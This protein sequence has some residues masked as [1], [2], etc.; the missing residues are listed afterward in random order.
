MADLTAIARALD[1]VED[2]LQEPIGV[3]DMADAADYS[4][5]HFCRTFGQAAHV[6]PYDYLMRRRLAEAAKDLLQS[7]DKIIDVAFDYQFNNPETFSRA[8]RRTFGLPPSQWRQEGRLDCRHIMP[9]LTLD[10]LRHLAQGPYLKPRLVD[11]EAL[12][13]AGLMTPDGA[14]PQA[15]RRIWSLLAADVA[16]NAV[17]DA[18]A[19]GEAAGR[20]YYGLLCYRNERQAPPCYLA[21]FE[22]ES[23]DGGTEHPALVTKQIPPARW[24]RFVHKGPREH[25]PLT[26][27]YVYYIWVPQSGQSLSQPWVLEHY[28]RCLPSFDDA[29]A[30]TAIFLPLAG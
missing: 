21:A 17:A 14:D 3:A 24:A 22:I 26:F 13:L 15:V 9:R 6:T 28:G 2:H 8:F 10:H 4:L 18:D 29:G 1:F 19:A 12:C 25:L 7:A 30:E 23:P 16:A 27:D 11:R 20:N 5:W